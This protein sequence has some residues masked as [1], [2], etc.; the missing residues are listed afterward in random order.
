MKELGIN[1]DQLNLINPVSRLG[2]PQ[3]HTIP[4][5]VKS[6]DNYYQNSGGLFKGG[7]AKNP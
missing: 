7:P 6:A 4:N 5:N 3:S 1:V 2:Q